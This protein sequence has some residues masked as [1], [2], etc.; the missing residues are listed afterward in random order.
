MTATRTGE[1][2]DLGAGM[3]ILLAM[4]VE[5]VATVLTVLQQ[6]AARG[7][8]PRT[9]AA[10][11]G[12]AA[13]VAVLDRK[14]TRLNSSHAN[15]SYAVFCSTKQLASSLGFS[16]SSSHTNSARCSVSPHS[17]H[18]LH[19]AALT[20]I[21]SSPPRIIITFPPTPTSPLCFA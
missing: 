13:V 20:S 1:G 2:A 3:A 4:I 9:L 15:I 16:S 17:A 11:A 14:S 10:V 8:G 21:L 7:P 12:G 19:V 6:R 18:P 5:L